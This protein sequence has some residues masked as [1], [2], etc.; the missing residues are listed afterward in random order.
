MSG[1]CRGGRRLLPPPRPRE[2]HRLPAGS[3][4]PPPSWGVWR[5]LRGARRGG[6][7]ADGG[8][9]GGQ[10]GGRGYRG[11]RRR[12]GRRTGGGGG[13][14]VLASAS[15]SAP[16]AAALRLAGAAGSMERRR[17]KRGDEE[18]AS[19][20][21]R[22]GA[23][24]RAG[25]LQRAGALGGKGRGLALGLRRN[26]PAC[27]EGRERAPRMRA[28]R[29]APPVREGSTTL[30]PGAPSAR[31]WAVP[32]SSSPRKG[33]QLKEAQQLPPPTGKGALASH[34]RS[35]DPR[36]SRWSGV[37]VVAVRSLSR[38]RLLAATTPRAAALPA[39]SLRSCPTSRASVTHL[40]LCL[41]PRGSLLQSPSSLFRKIRFLYP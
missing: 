10:R 11:P 37:V 40:P 22:G 8:T 26:L 4:R 31:A 30:R 1:G 19:G 25:A 38:A 27:A 18:A 33:P 36:L 5:E 17:E 2:T 28:L 34:V 20:A 7:A 39:T 13:T 32:G 15:A 9:G 35:A 6:A 23:S 29:G 16:A 41:C 12:G 21:G 3:G 24:G 14:S